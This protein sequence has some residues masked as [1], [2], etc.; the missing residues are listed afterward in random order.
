MGM[1]IKEAWKILQMDPTEDEA[2]IKKQY[3][4][5]LPKHN[6]EDDPEGF[7][8]LREAYELALNPP[9]EEE[10]PQ[11]PD[12]DI[13][14]WL[15]KV[16]P[17][18]E[19]MYLRRDAEQW[20]ELLSDPLCQGLDTAYETRERLLVF[21]MSH[22]YLPKEVWKL[23]D[24]TFRIV[25]EKEELLE[26]FPE[27]FLDYVIYQI[28]NDTFGDYE[29]FEQKDG[30][31]PDYDGYINLFYEINR[32]IT[33]LDN[34]IEQVRVEDGQ[35][36]MR[37]GP[38]VFLT[39]AQIFEKNKEL[40]DVR[41]SVH[42]KIAELDQ[43]GVYH[44]YRD[45]EE[46]R[47]AL[48][49]DETT[50]SDG[51]S[52]EVLAH[53]LSE[54]YD[55]AYVYRVCGE[56]YAACDKWEEAKQ[57]WEKALEKIPDH[58]MVHYDMARYEQHLGDFEK[59]ENIIRDH[60]QHLNGSPKVKN[61][62]MQVQ[63]SR[64]GQYLERLEKDP[65]DLDAW[66]EVCWSRFHSDR[67]KETLEMLDQKTFTP[68]T[69]EYYDYVDMKGRCLLEM[70]E[71]EEAL[72][73]LEEWEKALEELPDDG[74]EK[75]KKRKKT[76][77]YQRFV[78]AECYGHLAIRREEPGLF[79]KA[80]EYIKA[81]IEVEWDESMMLPYRDLLQRLRLR[82]GRYKEVIDD[83][84]EQIRK[85]K[86][87]LPAY[88]RRQEAYYQLRDAQGV[89]DDYH[90][91]LA[92]YRDYYRPY[93]LALRVFIA[94]DQFEDA[95][96]VLNAA[97][98]N[99]ISNVAI[100]LEE[101]KLMHERG[102]REEAMDEFWKKAN[103]LLE[104]VKAQD[105]PG[106]EAYEDDVVTED[107]VSFEMARVLTEQEK[108]D[109]ALA[110]VN[111]CIEKGTGLRNI[112]MLRANLLRMMK[113]YDEAIGFYKEIA[114]KE[115]DN[116]APWY[117]LGE[118]YR[119]TEGDDGSAISCYKHVLEMDEEEDRAVYELARCYQR[120]YEKY[121]A[122]KDYEESKKYFDKLVE[123]NPSAF[124]MAA[125][126]DL[127]THSGDLDAAIADLQSALD[128]SEGGEDDA[129]DDSYRLY[130]IG[131]MHYLMR[132]TD[133]AER[134]FRECIEKYGSIQTAPIF[135]LADT[136]GSK[137]Q[138]REAVNILEKYLDEYK[139]R[140]NYLNKLAEMYICCGDEETANRYYDKMH[141][142]DY[143]NDWQIYD[144]KFET[145]MQIHPQDF[146]LYFKEYDQKMREVLGVKWKH[147]H[148]PSEVLETFSY[149]KEDN[150]TLKNLATYFT[151][152]GDKLLYARK[153]D[154]AYDY[155]MKG[156]IL[157]K[158]LG[159]SRIGLFRS[160]ALCCK[161]ASLKPFRGGSNFGDWKWRA[162]L[163]ADAEIRDCIRAKNPPK[164]IKEM[165]GENMDTE[166]YY[167]KSQPA[168]NAIRY[169]RLALMYLI[170]GDEKKFAEYL[171][172]IDDGCF[173]L[174]CRYQECYD[175]L[176]VLG[177]MAEFKGDKAKAKEYF[178]RA[179]AISPTDIENTMCLWANS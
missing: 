53:E 88:M 169:E 112:Y 100:S 21:I 22:Q 71:Y 51:R 162:D 148:L 143:L 48:I 118:C 114:E 83:C 72:K 101:L 122:L 146:D 109:E 54:K 176:I 157:K 170:K 9:K 39:S 1:D 113:R 66:I 152:V 163:Y 175:R 128:K 99:G 119:A 80:I 116:T 133:E 106:P 155:L 67:I 63:H 165:Q 164:H 12:D 50:L 97:K 42:E 120:R 111:S 18:Y 159:M 91:I 179:V 75:Y 85:D 29:L 139:D 174:S 127:L 57:C 141:E 125:R 10:G 137:G 124:V 161:L 123:M 144:A 77:G 56:A 135:Q 115:P 2:A 65:D 136:L 25:E 24:D 4:L 153:L 151:V 11:E 154:K 47:L 64:E 16:G 87:N 158:K 105:P 33:G 45:V 78:F 172:H 167:L 58:A 61:F 5:L 32:M 90:S 49:E 145:M 70:E 131:D 129:Y 7:K 117:Y 74:S 110:L 52:I 76:L 14:L 94:Y 96:Q 43:K 26:K 142:I 166:E 138:W 6:P 73:Y 178:A 130:R 95:D 28:D 68:G 79:D 55:E 104:E 8:S 60:I 173:C 62:F 150:E 102:L 156:S 30:E 44:P 15:K 98:E 168:D 40:D 31:E 59:A 126:A 41:K 34:D 92:L 86:N 36:E 140:G 171:D 82:A 69:S 46:I 38:A 13:A 93:L 17:V 20:K 89:V 149:K 23:L 81:A 19:D 121:E 177:Y 134:I 27:N 108:K 103:S 160:L 147:I 84:D 3:K 37:E 132:R 35:D 107:M